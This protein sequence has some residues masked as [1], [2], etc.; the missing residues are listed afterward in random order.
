MKTLKMDFFLDQSFAIVLNKGELCFFNKNNAF[1]RNISRFCFFLFFEA[2]IF[3][4][5]LENM[6]FLLKFNLTSH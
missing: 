5:K 6:S 4:V 2:N 1:K 3:Q